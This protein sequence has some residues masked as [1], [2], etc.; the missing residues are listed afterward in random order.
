VKTCVV[1]PHF[2][3][4]DQFRAFLPTL[5][6]LELP[7][8]IVDDCSPAATY[9]NL[10]QLVAEQAPGAT[11]VARNRNRGKGA[12]VITGLQA[13]FARGFTHALQI[14]ADGQHSASDIGR[15]IAASIEQ[16]AHI[17]CGL[18]QF[19]NSISRLRYYSRY[20]TLGFCRMETW[21]CEI[22]DAMCG[23]RNYPLTSIIPILERVRIGRRMTFDPEIL[24]RAVWA[25]I[26]LSFQPVAVRYPDNGRS[27]FRYFRDNIEISWMHTRLLIG[28]IFRAP[29]LLVRRL[30]ALERLVPQ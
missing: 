18:P 19:D 9:A 11:L 4:V 10:Q 23:F 2:D 13:A 20:L 17:I 12:A 22:R 30:R 16:P 1:V 25:G 24:V 6:A 21:S 3:H 15:L 27:H 14:D 8:L 29:L 5:A 7:I 26:P 28:M